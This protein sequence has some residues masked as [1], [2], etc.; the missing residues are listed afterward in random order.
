[1]KVHVIRAAEIDPE[2]F[3]WIGQILQAQTGPVSFYFY[4]DPV[5]PVPNL[6]A[7]LE[8]EW[9]EEDAEPEELITYATWE[10]L[11]HSC[12]AF[13]TE[14][15]IAEDDFVIFLTPQRNLM[16][17]F[18]AFEDHS[19]NIF[20]HADEWEEYLHCSPVYPITYL[21]MSQ[22]LQKTLYRKE[23]IIMQ[24]AHRIP[25]GCFLD[26][27]GDKRQV[28]FK[29][30][31]ADI[32]PDCLE[33]IKTTGIPVDL[34]NQALG[35]FEAVRKEMLFRQRFKTELVPGRLHITQSNQILLPDYRKELNLSPLQKAIYFFFLKHPKGI[36]LK[37]RGDY[38]DELLLLYRK[39]DTRIDE[40]IEE[41]G[42]RLN[43]TISRLTDPG[44]NTMNEHLSRINSRINEQL[45][46]ELGS[47][48]VIPK[49]R[50][51]LKRIPLDRSLVSCDSGII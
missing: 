34:V 48:Y 38:K 39:L 20:I 19:N 14:K 8:K 36:F 45:G 49:E 11:F 29:L 26:F 22:I 31:T 30:R 44:E 50:G 41:T 43:D 10:E 6:V 40:T 24:H 13:R 35:L 17:W 42:R 12:G 33:Y 28:V 5:K 21:V 18:S 4:K 1:M 37:H 2:S 16:N 32:C 7:E 9:E 15:K 46:E 51:G 23:E 3:N 47:H 27:C 25:I